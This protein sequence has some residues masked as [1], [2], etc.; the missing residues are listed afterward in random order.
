MAQAFS[1][2]TRSVR[3]DRGIHVWIIVAFAALFTAAWL[4]WFFGT[5]T[6]VLIASDEARLEVARSVH[7][8]Q[9]PVAGRA[10]S[11][12]LRLGQTVDEGDVLVELDPRELQDELRT[13]EA[14]LSSLPKERDA[15]DAAIRAETAALDGTGSTNRSGE[16]VVR[17]RI[18]R[19]SIATERAR[20]EYNRIK[21]LGDKGLVP[22]KDVD[23]AE[24]RLRELEAAEQ[25]VRSGLGER[26]AQ[27]QQSSSDREVQIA[28]LE[29]ERA[30]LDGEI[31][32]LGATIESLRNRIEDHTLRAPVAGQLGDTPELQPGSFVE[33]GQTIGS[34]VPEG[35]V[36][37]VAWL[38]ANDAAGRVR[39]GQSAVMRLDGFPWSQYGVL[40]ATVASIAREPKN[41]NLR[42]DLDVD[43]ESAGTEE[44]LEHGLPGR[45]EVQVESISPATLVLRAA[46]RIV[47]G[48]EP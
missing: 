5:E 44:M 47:S 10:L 25:S 22:A 9:S 28:H 48:E 12:K 39:T 31:A 21:A 40:K 23:E 20:E 14:Q 2:T 33:R 35:E 37:I 6:N 3:A 24:G 18:R 19:A 15:L 32:R 8:V 13:L 46:G 1:K 34:I 26:R 38:A 36:R 45:V 27:G 29:R 16:A 17:A 43:V 30:K 41:G 7:V 42:V 11:T 4:L